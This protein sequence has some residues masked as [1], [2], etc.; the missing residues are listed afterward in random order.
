LRQ[1][2][3]QLSAIALLNLSGCAPPAP[4]TP[5]AASAQAGTGTILSLRAVAPSIEQAPLRAALLVEAGGDRTGSRQFVEFIVRADDG[6]TLSIVQENEPD[7]RAG[8]R[9]IILRGGQ[10]RLARPG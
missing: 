2:M 6:A 7:F 1:L 5:P 9:V 10:T 4:S 3:C 8:D